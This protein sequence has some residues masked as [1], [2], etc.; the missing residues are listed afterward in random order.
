[1]HKPFLHAGI[2]NLDPEAIIQLDRALRRACERVLGAGT[3]SDPMWAVLVELAGSEDGLSFEAL[4]AGLLKHLGRTM[5]LGCLS[6]LQE[7]GLADG[8]KQSQ[9]PLLSHIRITRE[10]R[11]TI[12]QVLN[13]ALGIL[14]R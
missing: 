5:L 11:E 6:N 9:G 1:M 14:R 4:A 2:E 8:H 3:L 7:A 13:E 12:E 10:G